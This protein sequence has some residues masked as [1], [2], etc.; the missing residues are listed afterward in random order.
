MWLPLQGEFFGMWTA[1]VETFDSHGYP[2]LFIMFHFA[3]F[4]PLLLS[5]VSCQIYF[6]FDWNPR[7]L[8]SFGPGVGDAFPESLH[9]CRYR[10]SSSTSKYRLGWTRKSW[11]SMHSLS[12]LAMTFHYLLIWCRV[13]L[14]YLCKLLFFLYG[15]F[16]CFLFILKIQKQQQKKTLSDFGL[17]YVFSN[18]SPAWNWVRLSGFRLKP[19]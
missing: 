5:E 2:S 4:F 1:H 8:V 18:I 9:I 3:L 19:D 10:S 7:F 16:K 11:I 13:S 15:S 17:A 12:S 6:S 14:F